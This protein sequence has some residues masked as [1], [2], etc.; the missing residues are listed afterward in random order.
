SGD[1]L[2][3]EGGIFNFQ[4]DKTDPPQAPATV[5]AG[6]YG[7]G[8]A[9]RGGT[10]GNPAGGAGKRGRGERPQGR[11]NCRGFAPHGT[12]KAPKASGDCPSRTH[13]LYHRSEKGHPAPVC[14]GQAAAGSY[15][16]KP[17]QVGGQED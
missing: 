15:S 6:A 8:A 7:G 12:P 13:H 11:G 17:S 10:P 5:Q 1:F 4:R 9:G 16:G 14:G 2:R 3:L